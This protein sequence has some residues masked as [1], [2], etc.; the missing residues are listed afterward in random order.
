MRCT[1]PT[2]FLDSFTPGDSIV[3][4][5][6]P[7]RDR[8]RANPYSPLRIPVSDPEKLI[9]KKSK[10]KFVASTIVFS[11]FVP[12]EVLQ[13]LSPDFVENLVPP[14]FPANKQSLHHKLVLHHLLFTIH[15]LLFHKF[16]Q[17]TPWQVQTH[18]LTEWMQLFL[19]GMPLW[20]YL[21]LLMH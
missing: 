21:S 10:R 3:E 12:K 5:L 13:T 20:F 14:C 4:F 8:T 7:R 19:Q 2:V 16:H 11:K 17:L 18:P 6:V 9:K 15:Q 1:V